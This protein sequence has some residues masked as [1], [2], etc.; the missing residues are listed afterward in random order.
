[1]RMYEMEMSTPD[2]ER[3]LPSLSFGIYG[4]HVT[5]LSMCPYSYL[6][7][8]RLS[9]R[10]PLR[11]ADS[12][13]LG[14]RGTFVMEQPVFD[15]RLPL[16]EAVALYSSHAL[17]NNSHQ[18][19]FT[20]LM[21][22]REGVYVLPDRIRKDLLRHV[23][24]YLKDLKEYVRTEMKPGTHPYKKGFYLELMGLIRYLR[25]GLLPKGTLESQSL[26]DM[27]EWFFSKEGLRLLSRST[28]RGKR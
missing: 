7:R 25:H 19:V 9:K 4:F 23:R 12:S 13:F 15:P 6:V 8:A 26:V 20:R 22:L 17:Y 2:E 27:C 10:T 16:A 3:V 11:R 28:C 1:M 18:Q 24:T 5:G 21:F 14:P